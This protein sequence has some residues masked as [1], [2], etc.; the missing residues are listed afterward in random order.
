MI[1]VTPP[2]E[3]SSCEEDNAY[4]TIVLYGYDTRTQ[5]R[6]TRFI[7]RPLKVFGF[8]STIAWNA[9]ALIPNAFNVPLNLRPWVF[10]I[11]IFWLFGFSAGLFNL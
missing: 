6:F 5:G 10:L 1:T 2:R 9:A 8:F 7:R 11:S 3:V 4:I